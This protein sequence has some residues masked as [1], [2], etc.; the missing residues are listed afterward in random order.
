MA[1]DPIPC[2]RCHG[3]QEIECTHCV[4]T[5]Q[6]DCTDVDCTE[7]CSWCGGDARQDCPDCYEQLVLEKTASGCRLIR[8]QRETLG[9]KRKT[10]ADLTIEEKDIGQVFSFFAKYYS[11]C[12]PIR[13]AFLVQTEIPTQWVAIVLDATPKES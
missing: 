6:H 2:T 1:T 11:H 10:I 8:T 9:N 4:G 7:N 13:Q 12:L 3:T 5:G